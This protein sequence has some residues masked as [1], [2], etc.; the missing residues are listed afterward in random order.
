MK[1]GADSFARWI[2]I[3]HRYGHAFF[4]QQ[5]AADG[6]GSG[7]I[8]VFHHLAKNPGLSQD[9][10]SEL[11]TLDKTTV[12]RAVKKLVELGYIHR[13]TDPTD[14]RCHRLYLTPAC[15]DLMPKIKRVIGEWN[16]VIS[17]DLS[18]EEKEQLAQGLERMAENARACKD[19]LTDKTRS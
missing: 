18:P 1:P 6:I 12:A 9:K 3:I 11:T 13:E 7:H 16:R 15:Q 19:A 17:Q 4:N 2:S 10:L 8:T 14:R 5:M